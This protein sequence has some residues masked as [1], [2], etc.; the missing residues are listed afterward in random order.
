MGKYKQFCKLHDSNKNK[1]KKFI[2]KTTMNNKV[3][4]TPTKNQVGKQ[5]SCPCLSTQLKSFCQINQFSVLFGQTLQI[6]T[7]LQN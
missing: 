3:E 2:E 1:F 5:I 6:N 7:H 4:V